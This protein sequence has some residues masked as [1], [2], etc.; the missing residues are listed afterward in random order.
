MSESEYQFR[1]LGTWPRKPT[2]DRKRHPFKQTYSDT[3]RIM[4]YELWKL[5]ALLPIVIEA[6]FPEW[7]IRNDGRIRADAPT[8]TRPASSSRSGQKKFGPLKFIC[9]DCVSWQDNIRAIALTLTRLRKAD[10][11]GVTKHSGAIHPRL[12]SVAAAAAH[13]SADDGGRRP[14][15]SSAMKEAACRFDG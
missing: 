11:Y 12:A 6:D 1:P 13:A 9:D 14:R 10:I 15:V 4:D 5:S 3:L 2:V 7:A 8:E